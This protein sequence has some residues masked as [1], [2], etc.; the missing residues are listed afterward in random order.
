[1]SS[2]TELG[3]EEPQDWSA[4]RPRSLAKEEVESRD[5]LELL[6]VESR[7]V[8]VSEEEQL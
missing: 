3:R 8:V 4:R 2:A 7:E 5:S 6:A 1:M